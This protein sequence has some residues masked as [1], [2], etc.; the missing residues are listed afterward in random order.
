MNDNTQRK[1]LVTEC[2]CCSGALDAV[3]QPPLMK[4][5]E[6]YFLLTCWNKACDMHGFTLAD[7]NY[8]D[9]DLAPYLCSGKAGAA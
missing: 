2:R 8:M 4:H 9:T 6:G 7:I 3:W 5:R 1:P